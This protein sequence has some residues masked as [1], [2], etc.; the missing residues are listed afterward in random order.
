[1][2]GELLEIVSEDERDHASTDVNAG[3]DLG[4]RRIEPTRNNGPRTRHPHPP[5]RFD[6]LAVDRAAEHAL[7]AIGADRLGSH[8]RVVVA[9]RGDHVKWPRQDDP[10]ACSQKRPRIGNALAY[11]LIG[12]AG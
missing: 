2:W 12:Q 7:D 1:L 10:L 4:E 3:S 11:L 5:Q 8:H 6:Y 9:K